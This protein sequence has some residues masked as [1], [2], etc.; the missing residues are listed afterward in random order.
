MNIFPDVTSW[1]K[2]VE[3]AVKRKPVPSCLNDIQ[4]KYRALLQQRVFQSQQTAI[5]CFTDSYKTYATLMTRSPIIK[6]AFVTKCKKHFLMHII[7]HQRSIGKSQAFDCEKGTRNGFISLSYFNHSCVPHIVILM[8]EN[9]LIG[10]TLRPIVIG[11]QVFISYNGVGVQPFRST[12][13]IDLYERFGFRC[14]C[15]RCESKAYTTSP[16]IVNADFEFIQS[17]IREEI[18][19]TGFLTFTKEKATIIQNKCIN[20]LNKFG[21]Q[22][23]SKDLELLMVALSNSLCFQ[24]KNEN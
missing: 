7:A 4:S 13:R 6:E 1:M 17:L 3:E 5:E 9:R 16:F 14:K 22:H 2:F 10:I 8:H 12:D 15:E 21:R 24:L 18:E 20:V 23:W 11:E 19:T